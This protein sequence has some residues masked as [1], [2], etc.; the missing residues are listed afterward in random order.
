[1]VRFAPLAVLGLS[2]LTQARF[3]FLHARGDANECCPCPSEDAPQYPHTVTVTEP[4]GPQKT[5]TISA[6]GGSYQT[7]TVKEPGESYKTITV[8]QHYETPRIKTVYISQGETYYPLK[9]TVTVTQPGKTMT[10]TKTESEEH[11]VTKKV[12][13][14]PGEPG[15]SNRNGY[16]PSP[17]TITITRD[18]PAPSANYPDQAGGVVTKIADHGGEKE[19]P[20]NARTYT[21]VKDGEVKTL[22][23]TDGYKNEI[24]KTITQAGGEAKTFTVT[25]GYKG[26][27]AKTITQEGGE[28]KTFTIT[29]G[30]KNK[31]V[32]T[33][34]LDDGDVKT[35]TI[36]DDY[37]NKLVKTITEEDGYE[38]TVT[39]T[40]GEKNKVIK[41]VTL[42]DGNKDKIVTTITV[43]D[44][45]KHIVTKTIQDGEKYHT[46]IVKHEPTITTITKENGEYITTVV[47]APCTYTLTAS[48]RYQTASV[49]DHDDCETFTRTATYGGEPEVEIIVY[50]PET[51]ESTCK[52]QEDGEPCHPGYENDKVGYGGDGKHQYGEDSKAQPSEDGKSQ[53]EKPGYS[54]APNPDETDCDS[55]AVSTSFATVYNTVVVTVN[56][57]YDEAPS[58][59]ATQSAEQPIYRRGLRAAR[60]LRAPFALRR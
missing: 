37:K 20:G 21:V 31:V 5:V 40:G 49:T 22:T 27:I 51:G 58:A 57:G 15:Y 43:E 30:Y 46:V 4:A 41:T 48:A 12:N 23:I 26:E 19:Y 45:N 34:T 35:Y 8:T 54:D 7:V 55:A 29:N 56:P 33:L 60:K 39:I 18:Y 6:P 42:E 38:K 32:K 52:K 10:V 13:I 17:K 28:V 59:T 25:N 1:M 16:Q 36:M 9:E 53:Y 50:D 2:H 44:S 3:D 24:V 11:V 47:E 14:Y